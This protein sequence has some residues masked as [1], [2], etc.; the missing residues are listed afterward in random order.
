MSEEAER[1][2]AEIEATRAE[3]AETADALAAKLDVKAQ[4]GQKVHAVG[5]KVGD[6][7]ASLR[8]SA[9]EPV[10]KVLG[11]A[12]HAAQPV[13]AKAAEDKRRTLFVIAGSVVVVLVI[14]RIRR[15]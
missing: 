10:Q 5:E 14:R 13:V 11:K 3:L 6:R 7:Y 2:K 4:A 1:L 12:E 15:K 8:N 9:P